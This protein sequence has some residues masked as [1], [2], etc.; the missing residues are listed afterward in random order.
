MIPASSSACIGGSALPAENLC[1]LPTTPSGGTIP[2]HNATNLRL[3]SDLTG[4]D[5]PTA[6]IISALVATGEYQP[7]AFGF[8]DA[9]FTSHVKVHAFASEYQ[10]KTGSAPSVELLMKRFPE[11]PYDKHTNVPWAVHRMGQELESRRSRL[12]LTQA[13]MAQSNEGVEAMMDIITDQLPR[14]RQITLAPTDA[15]DISIYDR[16]AVDTIPVANEKLQLVTGGI[17]PGNLWTVVAR[18][19]VGK[20][21]ELIRHAIE[22]ADY[23][24][25][26]ALFSLEMT[27][28]EVLNRIHTQI[29]GPVD[30]VD[31]RKALVVEWFNSEGRGRIHIHE[32]SNGTCN[33]RL[34][35]QACQP[36]TMVMIDHIGLIRANS[37]ARMVD[38]HAIAAA[39]VIEMKEIALRTKTPFIIAAQANRTF[40][41]K[42]GRKNPPP[43]ST[44]DISGTDHVGNSSDVVY[45]VLG[46]PMSRVRRG[47]MVKNRHGSA[48]CRWFYD[49]RP[50]IGSFTQISGERYRYLKSLESFDDD[51]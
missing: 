22:A 46:H 13:V 40:D 39:A 15:A 33:P 10:E 1:S 25:D 36:N 7:S 29:A 9:D 19:S 24:Y 37:G 30:N 16:A 26:V 11:F 51:E 44:V 2:I 27:A 43:P 35:E 12:M 47:F 41:E 32:Q 17:R 49:F 20:S 18:T 50:S 5:D 21:I 38:D 28:D 42:Q 23:G 14:I 34:I 8:D 48:D 6:Q 3:A 31:E 45:F 4:N